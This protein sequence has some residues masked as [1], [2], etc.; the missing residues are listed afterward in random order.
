MKLINFIL[1]AISVHD[2]KYDYSLVEYK[3][4]TSKIKIICKRHGVF[5]QAPKNHLSGQG[6]RKCFNESLLIST[7]EFIK[8]ANLIHNYKY[9]YSLVNY[10]KNNIKVRIICPIHG[11]FLQS[12]NHHLNMQQGC[13]KCKL[14]NSKLTLEDFIK[15]SIIKHGYRYSYTN[16]DGFDFNKKVKIICPIHGEF[17]QLPNNHCNLGYGCYKCKESNGEKLIASL[18]DGMNIN[19]IRE[20]KFDTCKN[21][22]HL[23]FDFYLPNYNI[24]IEYQGIQHFKPLNYFGGEERFEKQRINDEIKYNWCIDNNINLIIIDNFDDIK[25]KLAFLN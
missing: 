20:H 4:N 3:N 14:I 9:D 19:Y 2:N 8:R 18:L 5:E 23:L 21:K 10:I 15:K 17:L 25:K 24:C 6:C 7:S 12:P 22:N 11:E 1:N 13:L 16:I